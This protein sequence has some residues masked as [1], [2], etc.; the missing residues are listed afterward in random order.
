M[1]ASAATKSIF[2]EFFC[3]RGDWRIVKNHSAE[4]DAER[5]FLPSFEAFKN[6]SNQK[7]AR[8]RVAQRF[9][10][11]RRFREAVHDKMF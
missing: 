3:E 5:F 7:H 8:Q 4:T 9:Y 10:F 1:S 2:S 11:V 6:A